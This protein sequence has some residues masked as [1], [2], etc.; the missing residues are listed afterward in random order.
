[1]ANMNSPSESPHQTEL[2]FWS[3]VQAV[4]IVSMAAGL[5]WGIRGQ[6]G[7]ES[8]A[9]IAG[10]LASL[11]LILFFTP[12][13]TS[14]A[15][16]RAAAM[17]T[18]GIG[19]GG[20]MTYG[21]TVGL[22]HD[23]ELVGNWEALRWGMIGLATKGGLWIGFAG[24]FLGMG[25]GAV[26]YRPWEM[27]GLMLALIGALFLGKWLLNTPFDPANRVLPWIYFSDS[28]YFEPDKTDL[29]PRP[30]I[31]GGLAVA[32]ATLLA[33]TVTVRR[34][35]MSL[36]MGITGLIGGGIGFPFGQS[37]QAYLAWNL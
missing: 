23:Q 16:A 21:Q 29:K 12:N 3:I 7:H 14:L 36:R 11:S 19:I 15:A 27:L 6:Y 33:Y 30:E 5:G 25:L 10:A 24:T 1:M 9:M 34:D 17:M 20:T 8:G 31:W 4:V 13:A 2:S 22:T 35:W 18:V 28:W 26:K 32:L 37:I